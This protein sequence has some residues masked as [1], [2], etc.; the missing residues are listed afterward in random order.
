MT[1]A[2]LIRTATL[3]ALI[4]TALL[5]RS[6]PVA[7]ADPSGRTVSPAVQVY[8]DKSAQFLPLG[9]SKSIVVDP[10]GSTNTITFIKLTTNVGIE[11]ATFKLT[12]PPGTQIQDFT[13]PAPVATDA[14]VK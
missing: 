7:A 5:G 8:G 1:N 13:Q 4:V 9:V 10:D 12:P 11:E 6:A 2:T 14:G 3:A